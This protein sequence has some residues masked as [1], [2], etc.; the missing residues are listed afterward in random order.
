MASIVVVFSSKY[1]VC[2]T[3]VNHMATWETLE[4][5]KSGHYY[6]FFLL[7]ENGQSCGCLQPLAAFGYK[8]L[9]AARGRWDVNPLVPCDV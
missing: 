8:L 1:S 3:N 7:L 9:L 4:N 5:V 2:F 6:D